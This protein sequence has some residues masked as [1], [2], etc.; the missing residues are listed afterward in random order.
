MRVRSSPCARYCLASLRRTGPPC[1][2]WSTPADHPSSQ[3]VSTRTT[4]GSPRCSRPVSA[5]GHR[6]L[7]GA[8]VP[9]HRHARRRDRVALPLRQVRLDHPVVAAVRV[10]AAADRVA[11]LPFR[12][13]ARPGR[14]HRRSGHPGVL[15]RGGRGQRG[16]LPLQRLL[17]GGIAGVCTL[18]GILILVYRRRRDW[19]VF[20]ATTR[21][22]KLMYILLVAAIVLGL[23]TTLVSVGAGS[24]AHNYR[25]PCRRGSARCSSCGLTWRPW[26]R[27]RSSSTSTPW[28]EWRC[29]RSG[30][31]HAWF[32]RSPRRCTTCS[33][34]TSST[35]AGTRPRQGP[36]LP[37]RLESGRDPRPR[38]SLT[39]RARRDP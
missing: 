12:H 38:P 34:R 7:G 39:L 10:A 35:G 29:S 11:A 26:P 36:R 19:P 15:D 25:R 18:V 20:M 5:D 27:R 1:R 6:A 4:R 28:S 16:P 14:P 3:W 23:W 30:R 2:P 37:R 32:T 9:R 17:F 31:S 22:D 21:N 13:P 24:E 33:G 8:A